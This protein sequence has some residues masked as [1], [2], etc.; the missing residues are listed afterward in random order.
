MTSREIPS[1]CI[2]ICVL[3]RTKEFCVGC[4]RTKEEIRGWMK[5]TSEEKKNIIDLCNQRKGDRNAS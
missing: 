4:F 3:D 5:F 2:D 1:P